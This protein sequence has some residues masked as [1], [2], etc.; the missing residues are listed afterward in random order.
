MQRTFIGTTGNGGRAALG[1]AANALWRLLTG[2]V[3]VL[4]RPRNETTAIGALSDAMLK[5]IGLTRTDV[6]LAARGTPLDQ[7]RARHTFD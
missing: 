7:I 4:I 3:W 6:E 2:A 5:D 1:V